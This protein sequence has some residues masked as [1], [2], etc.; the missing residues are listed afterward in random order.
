M[1]SLV[2]ATNES[3]AN[4][5]ASLQGASGSTFGLV[6]PLIATVVVAIALVFIGSSVQRIEWLHTKL[7]A[8]SRS[9]Y[10]TVVGVATTI[11]IGVIAAPL[12]YVSQA[13]GQTKTYIGY[14]IGAVVGGYLVFTGLGY[15]VDR[16]VL[17]SVRKYRDMDTEVAA[18][19]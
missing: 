1:N 16:V 9:L 17:S 5:S 4:A 3:L 8:F 19:E 6:P 15:V 12:Y 10:Y 11:A 7:L 14:A 2:L 13:D 18:D